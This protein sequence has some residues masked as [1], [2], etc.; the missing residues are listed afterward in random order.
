[1]KYSELTRRLKKR[2]KCQ[3]I[4]A[5]L[6]KSHRLWKNLENDKSSEIPYHGSREIPR[7]TLRSFIKNLGIDW[8]DFN[9]TK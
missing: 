1:M 5:K 6:S 2:Y 8:K 9:N 7:G 4:K 3:E